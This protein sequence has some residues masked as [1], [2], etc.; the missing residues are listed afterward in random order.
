LLRDSCESTR[1]LNPRSISHYPKQK[2]QYGK[3]TPRMSHSWG[4]DTS[5]KLGSLLKFANV[6]VVDKGSCTTATEPGSPETLL[7]IA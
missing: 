4:A 7:C 6:V 5:M 1:D 2:T 3:I